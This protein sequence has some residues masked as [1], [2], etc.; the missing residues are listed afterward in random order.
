M[1]GIAFLELT[2]TK[3]GEVIRSEECNMITCILDD[4]YSSNQRDGIITRSY[5]LKDLFSKLALWDG[6]ISKSG[7][8]ID[9]D[10]NLIA[11]KTPTSTKAYGD[12]GVEMVFEF[13]TDEANGLISCLSLVHK[14]FEDNTIITRH[15]DSNIVS[16]SVI[17]WNT[18]AVKN[19][20]NIINIDENKDEVWTVESDNV[21]SYRPENPFYIYIKKYY[22]S[23]NKILFT[24]FDKNNMKLKETIAFDISDIITGV[25]KFGTTTP[26]NYYVDEKYQKLIISFCRNNEDKTFNTCIIDLQT[27]TAEKYNMVIP[28]D[29]TLK[30]YYDNRLA[31]LPC[32][33]GRI[34]QL[35]DMIDENDETVRVMVGIN[36]KNTTDIKVYETIFNTTVPYLRAENLLLGKKNGTCQTSHVF[37]KDNMA[38]LIY[39]HEFQT[40]YFNKSIVQ[41][42]GYNYYGKLIWGHT[43]DTSIVS[44]INELSSNLYKTD[45]QT[46]KITYRIIEEE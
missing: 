17:Y 4:I 14:D 35:V 23:Y 19:F 6:G 28:S 20:F 7:D 24:S 22:H 45:T 36:P 16:G 1:K 27:L 30:L 44:T 8:V 12:K 18:D 10:V 34:C 31:G 32:Y 41:T 5:V 26:F 39:N 29:I 3:T 2:D 38:Y 43:L 37:I 33:D 21:S 9:D 13:G 46:L 25:D 40:G 15:Y 11:I 42:I